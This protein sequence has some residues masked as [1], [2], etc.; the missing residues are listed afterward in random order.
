MKVGSHEEFAALIGIEWADRRHGVCLQVSD[1]S[2]LEFSTL[3]Q[4]PEAIAAWAH[5]LR[6]RFTGHSVAICL[7]LRKGPLGYALAKY[8]FLVLFPVHPQTVARYRRALTPSRAKDDP[9]DAA[10]LLDLLSRHRDKLPRWTPASPELRALHQVGE[11]RRKLVGD[12]VRLTNRLTAALKNYSPQ[13]LE[14]FAAK[15]TTIFCDFLTHWPT[16]RAVPQAPETTLRTFFQTHHARYRQVNDQ[17]LAQLHAAHPL[18]EDPGVIRPNQLLVSALVPQV[19]VVLDSIK[20]FDAA[21]TELCAQHEDAALFRSLP[22]AGPQYAPRLLVA[23][24]EDRA[25][26]ARAADLLQYAGIAPVTERSGQTSWVHWRYSCPTF[27]R[28]SS[29][30]WAGESIRPSFWASA[31]SRSQRAKGKSPQ[32]AIRAVAFK[33]IRLVFRCWQ[34]RKPYDEAKYLLALPA[35]GAPLL[36]AFAPSAS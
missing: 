15:D 34:T 21:I 31:F 32:M 14:W 17:R 30:E 36:T 28:Q 3:A 35:K 18:T 8:D 5:L 16:L 12:Q 27:L 4:Q 13:V 20:Q 33:G 26:S 24:G 25:R 22:G 6:Q 11:I 29:V 1:P 9:R 23:F 7:E 19:Q 2:A 10:V